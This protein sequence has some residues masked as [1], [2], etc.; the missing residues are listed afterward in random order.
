MTNTLDPYHKWL[1]I[2][3]TEQPPNHY[4]LLGITI[5]ENDPEVIEAA[6]DARMSHLKTYQ[7]GKYYVLS[8]RLLGE[9]SIARV[10]LLNSDKK[11][12]YDQ[13]LRSRQQEDVE[14]DDIVDQ[15]GY[16]L[17]TVK[18]HNMPKRPWP[19][20]RVTAVA[21]TVL[22]CLVVLAVGLTK[23]K[24]LS[25]DNVASTEA[26]GYSNASS[27]AEKTKTPLAVSTTT[28]EQVITPIEK[29]LE[30]LP[31]AKSNTL[32]GQSDGKPTAWE[33]EKCAL[34]TSAVVEKTSEPESTVAES[35]KDAFVTP[36]TALSTPAQVPTLKTKHPIPSQAVQKEILQQLNEIYNLST[37]KTTETKLKLAKDLFDL[38]NRSDENPN[39][40]FMLLREVIKLAQDIGKP[41][42]AFEA[43]DA[44]DADFDIDVL[45]IKCKILSQFEVGGKDS[46]QAEEFIDTIRSLINQARAEDRYDV[47]MNLADAA[48]QACLRSS[49]KQ[50]RKTIFKL[51]A[52]IKELLGSWHQV[53][54]AQEK[55]KNTPNDPNANLILGSWHCFVNDDWDQGLP[56]LAKSSDKVLAKLAEQELA[57]PKK[58]EDQVGLA[59]GWW[60]VSQTAEGTTR[61]AV[62]QRAL[63]WY[64]I[65]ADQPNTGL[66]KAKIEK[67]LNELEKT[68]I[69]IAPMFVYLPSGEGDDAN[70]RLRVGKKRTKG[71]KYYYLSEMQGFDIKKGPCGFNST[72][73][74]IPGVAKCSHSLQMHPPTESFSTVKY[75]LDKQFQMFAGGVVITRGSTGAEPLSAI[76]FAIFG[77]S[78]LL[79][80]S[81]PIKRLDTPQFFNVSVRGVGVIELRVICPGHQER[82]HAHWLDPHLQARRHLKSLTANK[83]TRES[84]LPAQDNARSGH[85]V[86]RVGKLIPS[87]I[88]EVVRFSKQ[89]GPYELMGQV[90]ISKKGVLLIERG[91]TIYAG[92]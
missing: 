68:R 37:A 24:D 18:V 61:L 12:E 7:L 63:Y 29:R 34:V 85:T 92:Q 1:G 47:A 76:T 15:T 14:S 6:A 88:E 8:E 20:H 33:A 44:I 90:L 3:P 54:N 2:P 17:P 11:A 30:T 75:R 69:K 74:V 89:D 50:A 67:R 65:A 59:D 42:L 5:F 66:V 80:R 91:T 79:W 62:K 52:S 70:Q 84:L 16:D 71:P 73:V 46:E 83:Q 9:V 32:I 48:Y 60:E 49:N 57:D 41:S 43:V 78:R 87:R 10:C 81:T 38:A 72:T 21:V 36:D 23:K 51:R 26:S 27:T 53:Q 25:D 77:D 35:A 58:L 28:A 31:H 4:R 13:D 40:R 19:R 82:A 64:E 86:K 55:L 45:N 56:L 22:L 39:E